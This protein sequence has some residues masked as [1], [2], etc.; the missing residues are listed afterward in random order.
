MQQVTATWLFPTILCVV[1]FASGRDT[2]AAERDLQVCADLNG[3]WQFRLDPKDEGVAGRWFAADVAFSDKI[4]VPGNWQSQG[5]GP[6]HAHLRHDYQGKAWY[7]R[8]LTAPTA[9]AG[10]RVWLCLGGVTNTAD[11]YVNGVK[12]GAVEGSTVPW[13]FDITDAIKLG[14]D[15]II[16]CRVDS[17]GLASGGVVNYMCRWGGLYRSVHC[18][19]RSDPAIQDVSV[20]PD[21]KNKTAHVQVRLARHAGGPGCKG[22]VLVRI[23]P[24]TGGATVEGRGEATI[25]DGRQA[26]EAISLDVVMPA[27]HAWS[28]EDP[29]LYNV[30]V[31]TLAEGK[32]IDTVRDRFGMRQFEVGP[33]GVLLL[34]GRPYF[35]RGIGDDTV[36]VIHGMQYPDKQI[37]IDRLKQIKRY[38]FNGVRFLGNTPIPEYFQAADEVGVLVM[39]EGHEY[40]RDKSTIPLLSKDVARIVKTFRNHPSWYIWSAGNELFCCQGA[41]PDREWMDYILFAQREFKKLDP[42]RFFIASDGTDVFPTDIISQFGRFDGNRQNTSPEQPFHG[43]IGEIAYFKRALDDREVAKTADRKSADSGTYARTIQALRPSGYWRFEETLPDKAIDSSG[44]NRHVVYDLTMKAQDLGRP[45]V[46]EPVSSSHAIHTDAARKGVRLKDVAQAAFSAGSEPFSISCW[47]NPGRFTPGKYGTPFAYGLANN[48]AALVIADDGSG[49]GKL[50]LGQYGNGFLHSDAALTSGQWNHIGIAY[51]GNVMKLFINGK[52]DKSEKVKMATVLADARIGRCITADSEADDKMYQERPQIWH[53][54][55]NSYIGPLPDVT[56]DASWTG[57]YQDPNSVGH[58]RKQIADLGLLDRYPQIREQSLQLFRG[59]LKHQF[60]STRHSPTMDG[61]AY[62]CMTDYPAGPEGEMTTYGMFNTVYKPD[63]FPTPEPVLQFNRETVLL[64]NVG[65]ADRVLE[66]GKV[67]DVQ[68]SIS[69]YGVGPIE[70][71]RV[72]WTLNAGDKILQKGT[73]EPVRAEVG[74]VKPLGTIAI[75]PPVSEVAQKLRLHVCLESKTC[76][77]ENQWDFWM[78]PAGVDMLRGRPIFNRTGIRELDKRYA[79]DAHRPADQAKLILTNRVTREVLKD[80][81][82]GRSVL[83][84]AEQ[85]ILAHPGTFSFYPQWIRSSGTVIEKH[86]ALAQFAHDGFCDLQFFR[87]FD[88]NLETIPLN[89]QGSAEREKLVPI[90]WGLCQD[91]DPSL[92]TEW[93]VPKNRW[94]MYRHGIICEGRTESGKILICTLRV[95]RGIESHQS[96]A[97]ALLDNLVEYATSEKFAPASPP[98]KGE[99]LGKMFHV[100]GSK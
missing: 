21:V 89:D 65:L 53:E 17:T 60:E 5:F 54:F 96:E 14:A 66:A 22:G 70:E 87:L 55:P 37:Y 23:T 50:L 98:I 82:Q 57:V 45:G 30:E 9:W 74:Q 81:A 20:I 27:M 62:W 58:A 59:Y 4:Q 44:N 84:L 78:F 2:A 32:T 47:V 69:H 64:A 42:T 8:T 7:R 6:S 39:A 35:V 12:I 90:A 61:Y 43:L 28:P 31:S 97:A 56:A 19:A 29:F 10:K 76:R 88:G 41:A 18:E 46:L 48:G 63:K 83:I 77:Q 68:L 40:T 13:E 15:N 3:T 94:K 52:F 75:Q 26:S 67:R 92:G 16:A 79:I 73:I 49:T 38:G 11:V 99:E 1:L 80:L 71:G 51:D 91:H 72:S 85:G 34:N 33:G 100:V 86:P 36:E 95:M 24:T 25:A 93:F